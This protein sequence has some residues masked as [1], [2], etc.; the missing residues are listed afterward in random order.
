MKLKNLLLVLLIPWLG[1]GCGPSPQQNIAEKA[2]DAIMTVP[3]N[4]SDVSKLLAQ[5]LS[6]EGLLER[7]LASINGNIDD[8]TLV[9]R[10]GLILE[11]TIGMD[12]VN[13][14]ID[15]EGGG[16]STRLPSGFRNQLFESLK[17]LDPSNPN[18]VEAYNQIM[19][20]LTAD[21]Q[22]KHAE[23]AGG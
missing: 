3:A 7:W 1:V 14:R 6:D 18:E 20:I 11:T 2:T 17:A 13:A 12:G 5:K 16:D 8:P 4:M 10:T 9:I 15:M 19:K 21:Q 23:P 22:K